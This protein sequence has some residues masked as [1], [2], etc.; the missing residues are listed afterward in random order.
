[1]LSGQPAYRI[2]TRSDVTRI[3][4]TVHIFTLKDGK[5]YTITYTAGQFEDHII[6]NKMM[7][8]FQITE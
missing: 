8:S 3:W 4:D 1:M 6:F 5:D 7:E 2:D